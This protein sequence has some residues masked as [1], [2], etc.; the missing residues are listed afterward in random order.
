MTLPFENDTSFVINK[1][2]SAQLKHDKLKKWLTAAAIALAAFL[3]TAVLLLASGIL[4]V[5]QTGGNHITGSYHALISGMTKEQYS[6]ISA[7]PR[8]ALSGLTAAVG[9]MKDGEKRLNISY[10][11]KDSL[12][13]NGLSV[14][15][16]EM[17]KAEN[18]IIIEEEYLLSQEIDAGIGDIISLPVSDER[19]KAD[20]VISGYLETAA[21]GTERTLY[22]AVVSEEYFAAIDGWEKF[23]PAVMFR[24]KKDVLEEHG[25]AADTAAQIAADAGIKQPV[26]V[27]EAFVKLS[28][29]SALMIAAAAAGLGSIAYHWHDS[30][31]DKKSCA[32]RRLLPYIGCRSVWTARR[33]SVILC[34]SAAGVQNKQYGLGL[35]VGC[36]PDL[37]HSAIVD[38]KTG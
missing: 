10:S 25:N 3:M 34:F 9:S 15:E 37:Y 11:N 5:N 32:E 22:A 30:K 4:Y 26:S 36:S 33:D 12:I 18:E 2:V 14:S 35:S 23:P 29:P 20:F 7:D 8:I 27:N 13:L 1:I 19:K 6:E 21:G 17:P 38:S 16:G 24:I 28:Q 31:T